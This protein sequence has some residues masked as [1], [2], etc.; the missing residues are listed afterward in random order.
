MN[1]KELTGKRFVKIVSRGNKAIWYALKIGKKLNKK[2]VIIQDQGGWI[3]YK[4]YP[5][6]L[7]LKL[8]ELETDHGLI[9]LANLKEVID[10][11]TILLI[12]S[13]PAYAV[14]ENMKAIYKE[15]KR[16]NA[17]LINDVSGSIGTRNSK[18]GHILV[19]SFGKDKPLNIGYGGFIASNNYLNL[20]NIKEIAI[21]ELNQKLNQLK[22]R[23]NYLYSL[24]KKIKNELARF[25]ILHKDK[26]GINVIVKFNSSKIKNKLIEYCEKNKYPYTLC[27]RY[28][29]VN[30]N[31][32]SIEV[33]R[34]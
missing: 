10:N 8:I 23:V 1:I 6:R 26:R 33:K 15:A 25:D 21:P 16:V 3:S 28:I 7:K 5:K 30:C 18:I 11:H 20:I 34:L 17:L 32:I 12:N 31:A 24:N 14:E 22:S 19:C 9:D 27:P 2:K 4:L 29:R 13:M